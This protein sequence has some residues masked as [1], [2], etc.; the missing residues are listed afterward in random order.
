MEETITKCDACGQVIGGRRKKVRVVDSVQYFFLHQWV[1]LDICHE[2][3]IG[4]KAVAAS[5]TL[6]N[7]ARGI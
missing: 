2:C 3:W 1:K 7:K 4:L 6:A 5:I